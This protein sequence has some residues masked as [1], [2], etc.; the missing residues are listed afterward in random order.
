MEKQYVEKNEFGYRVAGSRLSLDSIVYAYRE[1]KSP[2]AIAQDFVTLTHE[3][4][5]GAIAFYLA[6]RE[7]I[8]AYI[9]Q[10]KRDYEAKRQAARDTD[11][12]YYKKI[13]E[14]RERLQSA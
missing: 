10:G 9:E 1:G 2:E 7:E 4:I 12:E 14:A 13:K 3:Q 11:P 6:N 8:E 5:Y